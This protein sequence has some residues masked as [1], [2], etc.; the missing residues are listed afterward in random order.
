MRFAL[1][2]LT[3]ESRRLPSRRGTGARAACCSSNRGTRRLWESRRCWPPKHA[4]DIHQDSAASRL[5]PQECDAERRQDRGEAEEDS[6][7]NTERPGRY[8]KMSAERE[9]N[10]DLGGLHGR[11]ATSALPVRMMRGVGDTSSPPAPRLLVEE[12]ADDAPARPGTRTGLPLRHGL[13]HRSLVYPSARASIWNAGI[14]KGQ[15]E[16]ITVRM[17]MGAGSVSCRRM[18]RSWLRFA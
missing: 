13:L 16:R 5:G 6:E 3:R 17:S 1:S 8:P 2:R 11:K 4:H 14:M 10:R 9:D 15:D 12:R 7:C 18:L